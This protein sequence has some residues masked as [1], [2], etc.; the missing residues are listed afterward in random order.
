MPPLVTFCIYF[1]INLLFFLRSRFYCKSLFYNLKSVF[2]SIYF[3]YFLGCLEQ[4]LFTKTMHTAFWN[5]RLETEW[6][7]LM[8]LDMTYFYVFSYVPS[9][10]NTSHKCI[11]FV[12]NLP[13]FP[14][15]PCHSCVSQLD[16]KDPLVFFFFFFLKKS[17]TKDSFGPTQLINTNLFNRPHQ[18]YNSLPKAVGQGPT[19]CWV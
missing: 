13:I 12:E 8:E 11:V 1:S 7:S 14:G 18:C 10:W 9:Q 15:G 19:Q 2:L 4:W 5:W 17:I 16:S 6:M 3:S